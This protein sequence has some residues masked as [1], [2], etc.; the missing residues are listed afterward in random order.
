[1]LDRVR[2]MDSSFD[3]V[4]WNLNAFGKFTAKSYFL[5]LSFLVSNSLPSPYV[6]GFPW[7]YLKVCPFESVFVFAWEASQ[8]KVLTCDNLQKRSKIW[9]IEAAS[10]PIC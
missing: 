9:S 7:S 10:L 2:L 6:C 8:G 4:R 1:M 5:H 3:M